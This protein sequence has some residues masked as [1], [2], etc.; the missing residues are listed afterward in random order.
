VGTNPVPKGLES[1]SFQASQRLG[2]SSSLQWK[3]Y[4]F[5]K[6]ENFFF[7]TN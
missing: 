7:I 2:K 5:P 1:C 4:F 3:K 6:T